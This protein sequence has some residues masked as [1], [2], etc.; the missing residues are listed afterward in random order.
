MALNLKKK[1][2]FVVVDNDDD[3]SFDFEM[4]VITTPE[5]ILENNIKPLIREEYK[6]KYINN[7]GLFDYCSSFYDEIHKYK[8]YGEDEKLAILLVGL[9]ITKLRELNSKYPKIVS[10]NVLQTVFKINLYYVD[11][12]PYY[13]KK[14][15]TIIENISK[16]NFIRDVYSLYLTKKL[17]YLHDEI[18][19]NNNSSF[20][21]ELEM[22]LFEMRTLNKFIQKSRFN[23]KLFK[24]YNS[25][26]EAVYSKDNLGEVLDFYKEKYNM[27]RVTYYSSND[28]IYIENALEQWFVRVNLDSH[29][30]QLFHANEKSKKGYHK[31][32]F[33][34]NTLDFN[35]LFF[36]VYLH[37]KSKIN[38][39][40]NKVNRLFRYIE[41]ER[42]NKE[43]VLAQQEE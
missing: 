5:M 3:N 4:A 7:L 24:M 34:L 26:L 31:Q 42:L 37:Q 14:I 35:E 15:E 2:V 11:S 12:F 19:V 9:P 33:E 10:D 38:R 25:C 21:K 18:T 43:R 39:E 36:Y 30:I 27:A 20:S 40:Y 8:D 23:V 6:G 41:N 28:T 16:S 29:K 22:V 17:K 32:E 13:K 1:K